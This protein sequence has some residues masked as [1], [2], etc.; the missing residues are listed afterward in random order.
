MKLSVQGNFIWFQNPV[1]LSERTLI[2][3]VASKR[4][5]VFE[6]VGAKRVGVESRFLSGLGLLGPIF[7]R[8]A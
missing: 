2:K 5:F 7:H 3:I 4:R 6:L 1:V 8:F